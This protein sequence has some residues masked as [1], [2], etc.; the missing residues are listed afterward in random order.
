MSSWVDK[1]IEKL[2]SIG[3][4]TKP[5]LISDSVKLDS[6]ENY[7]IPKQFQNDILSI[8]RKNSDIREYPLGRI[9]ELIKMIS[10]FVK[11]PASMIGV[12]NGS[13]QI[14]DLILLH[15]ASKKTKILTSKPTFG[16]FEERC[17]LYS[18]PLIAIPFSDDMKLDVTEFE[19][20][21]KSTD[22]LYLD[23]PNN[24]T[25]SSI[26]KTHQIIFWSCNY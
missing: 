5:E 10:K 17:K 19:K 1:K 4:Y 18:I 6:N 13:D 8:A 2:S 22:I 24:P 23:S 26:T 15:F 9:D 3:G 25:G 14:L 11:I 16:F 20:N 21:S 12:G 7:V